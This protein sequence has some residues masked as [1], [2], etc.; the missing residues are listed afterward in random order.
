M[1]EV[2]I[3]YEAWYEVGALLTL[4]VLMMLSGMV[5]DHGTTSTGS[6]RVVPAYWRFDSVHQH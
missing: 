6:L 5:H 1:E 4:M 2:Q 3:L